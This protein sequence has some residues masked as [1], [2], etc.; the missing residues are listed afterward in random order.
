M[1][2]N[3][4]KKLI[5][6]ILVIAALAIFS[7][8]AFENLRDKNA[9]EEKAA[10]A[11]KSVEAPPIE[12]SIFYKPFADD[13]IYGQA[14]APVIVVEYASLS[15]THCASF[16]VDG[17]PKLKSEYIDNGKVKFIHRDFPLNQPA[18]TASMLALC[19]AHDNAAHKTARYY[20]FI[21]ALFK[22]QD[23]WAFTGNFVDKLRSIAKLDG[24]SDARFEACLKDKALQ[25][26]ILKSRLE[27]SRALQIQSTPTFLINGETI[28]GYSGYDEV[29]KLV[30]KKFAETQMSQIK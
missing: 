20:D 24:M 22:T 6:A 8:L 7:F 19:I 18:L 10:A 27:A 30:E 1:T 28:N 25:E 4:R 11:K 15:C 9:A 21:K 5:I 16:A 29:K 12:A 17:F 23:S 3:T 2:N 13:I 14:D 26:K